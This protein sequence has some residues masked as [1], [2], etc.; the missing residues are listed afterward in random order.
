MLERA[1][2]GN[3][4]SVGQIELGVGSCLNLGIFFLRI[5]ELYYFVSES[6]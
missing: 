5:I 1:D 4:A 3:S 2:G 6:Q